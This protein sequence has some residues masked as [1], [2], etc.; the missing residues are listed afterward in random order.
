MEAYKDLKL[1][2]SDISRWLNKKGINN[3]NKKN[4]F[5][6]FINEIIYLYLEDEYKIFLNKLNSTDKDNIQFIKKEFNEKIF[7]NN[8]EI[9]N[10]ILKQG[11]KISIAEQNIIN[12][13]INKKFIKREINSI[14]I[15]GRLGF[16]YKDFR[17]IILSRLNQKVLY[18]FIN[19]I[20]FINLIIKS[21]WI[22]GKTK[23]KNLFNNKK[24]FQYYQ[25]LK[26]RKLELDQHKNNAQRGPLLNR[27]NVFITEIVSDPRKINSNY[28]FIKSNYVITSC[29]PFAKQ[30]FDPLFL[31]ALELIENPNILY[32]ESYIFKY[33]KKLKS[34]KFGETFNLKQSNKYY[35]LPSEYEFFPWVDS[36]PRRNIILGQTDISIIEMRFFKIR[37]V[38]NNIIEFGYIPTCQDIIKGYF[39][40]KGGEYRFVVL[41]GWHRLAVLKALNSKNPTQFK[42]I[43]VAFDLYRSEIKICSAENIK[44]WPAIKN[45]SSN[46]FDA[47]EIFNS[48]FKYL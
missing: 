31:T 11:I 4:I 26:K 29:V 1:K 46:L 47:Q 43:P 23:I 22:S 45:S 33:L 5:H 34:T 44:I 9:Q 3:F 41:Q 13:I 32:K 17:T 19:N 25:P 6:I 37:N 10:H 48:Y 16:K 28:F 39:L 38:I 30:K 2:D 7:N 27:R 18:K 20:L 15:K 14:L 8:I 42:Y 21:F 35:D 40:I 12:K 24:Q 36:V